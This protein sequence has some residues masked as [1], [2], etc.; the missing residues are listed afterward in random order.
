LRDHKIII[1]EYFWICR[2]GVIRGGGGGVP[3]AGT[4]ETAL[5]NQTLP[6]IDHNDYCL[7][8]VTE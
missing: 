6:P 2:Y 8:S 1:N 7:K 4:A 5:P 3:G